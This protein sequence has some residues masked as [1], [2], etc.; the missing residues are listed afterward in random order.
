MSTPAASSEAPAPAAR[1]TAPVDAEGDG[2]LKTNESAQLDENDK[3]VVNNFLICVGGGQPKKGSAAAK[4]FLVDKIVTG[5]EA[6]A[7]WTGNKVHD[8]A[9][10]I[11]VKTIKTFELKKQYYK[12][13]PYHMKG[14]S[15]HNHFLAHVESCYNDYVNDQRR[16]YAAGVQSST[17]TRP[18]FLPEAEWGKLAGV[19]ATGMRVCIQHWHLHKHLSREEN[20]KATIQLLY[21]R[22]TEKVRPNH[23]IKEILDERYKQDQLDALLEL[24]M[25]LVDTEDGK[26]QEI[27]FTEESD[28]DG[29]NAIADFLDSVCFKYNRKEH[30]IHN[31]GALHSYIAQLKADDPHRA[32]LAR[33]AGLQPRK[34]PDFKEEVKQLEEKKRKQ[35]TDAANKQTRDEKKQKQLKEQLVERIIVQNAVV[36]ALPMAMVP[37]TVAAASSSTAGTTTTTTVAGTTTTTTTAV[38]GTT[39]AGTTTAAGTT[40]VAGTTTATGTREKAMRTT[41]KAAKKKKEDEKAIQ[42]YVLYKLPCLPYNSRLSRLSGSCGGGAK[43]GAADGVATDGATFDRPIKHYDAV[44]DVEGVDVSYEAP[45]TPFCSALKK[46]FHNIQGFIGLMDEAL[47][48]TMKE[49]FE[50]V[51]NKEKAAGKHWCCDEALSTMVAIF[52]DA[53]KGA[54]VG[55]NPA[56]E[57]ESECVYFPYRDHIQTKENLSWDIEAIVPSFL[58]HVDAVTFPVYCCAFYLLCAVPRNW[59][60]MPQQQIREKINAVLNDSNMMTES[61]A[62]QIRTLMAV[63]EMMESAPVPERCTTSFEPFLCKIDCALPVVGFLPLEDRKRTSKRKRSLPSS[64]KLKA[65]SE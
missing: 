3:A 14:N 37:S 23:V 48:T 45:S 19:I 62:E 27:V 5:L 58:S 61:V 21:K 22:C 25:E 65:A 47:P 9:C 24:Q 8:V 31:I 18:E 15:L 56:G 32:P 49:I 7:K 38:A 36:S 29:F 10:C 51:N 4:H 42:D 39:T 46:R 34:T 60:G 44:S 41:S 26:G 64:K 30:P 12:L 1:P 63:V 20:Y 17:L 57:L 6:A 11:D 35:E 16:S 53:D 59:G 52:L 55:L 28:E 40:T 50:R 13:P 54:T 43:D 2:F 33:F